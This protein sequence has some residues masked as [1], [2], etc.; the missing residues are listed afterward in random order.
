[1][2]NTALSTRTVRSVVGTPHKHYLHLAGSV[3]LLPLSLTDKP[4]LLVKVVVVQL[5]LLEIGKS[6]SFGTRR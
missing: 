3:S 5:S 4:R 2:L 6:L 1:M